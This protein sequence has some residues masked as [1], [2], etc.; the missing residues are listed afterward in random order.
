VGVAPC[1]CWELPPPH[2][3]MASKS[4]QTLKKEIILLILFLPSL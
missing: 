1:V 2:A 4:P 3:V